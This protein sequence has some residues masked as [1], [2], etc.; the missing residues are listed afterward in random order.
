M[1]CRAEKLFTPS[2]DKAADFIAGEFKKSGF[3][4][5]DGLTDYR[6]PFS[7][8][9]AN[10]ISASGSLNNH[11]LE[12]SQIIAISTDATLNFTEKSG[13]TK[14]VIDSSANLFKEAYEIT[15]KQ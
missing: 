15:A 2:I 9:K 4:Y 5:F 3:K 1:K 13:F 14:I 8:I 12:M 7:M 6:Q 10:L 11:P